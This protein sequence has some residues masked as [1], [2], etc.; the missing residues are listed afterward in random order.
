VR[1]L[2]FALPL[3]PPCVRTGLGRQRQPA[4]TNL[5]TARSWVSPFAEL[6]EQPRCC[7]SL[8]V[9]PHR[10]PLP[11]AASWERRRSFLPYGS[12]RHA[13]TA[14]MAV[15]LLCENWRGER[16]VPI[17]SWQSSLLTFQQALGQSPAAAVTD[18]PG[19]SA[20]VCFQAGR[21]GNL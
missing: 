1:R 5:L 8:A 20:R 2:P 19:C 10:F 18:V 14:N 15:P 17:A 11:Q 21:R 9:V 6:P 12:P 7:L 4:Q 3:L 16:P 13:A